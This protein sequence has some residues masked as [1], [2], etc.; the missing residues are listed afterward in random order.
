MSRRS[1]AV[2]LLAAV[3]LAITVLAP[4]FG[5]TLYSESF[6]ANPTASWTVN[7]G[8][9]DHAANFFFDYATVGIPAAP[10]APGTRGMKLQANQ[11]RGIFGGMSVS[12][13]GQSFAGPYTLAFDWWANF[14]GPFPAGGGGSTQLS[15]L[16]VQTSGTVSQWPGATQD[17]IWFGATGDGNSSSDWRVY[18]PSAPTAIP[19]RLRA[20]TRRAPRSAAAMRAIPT[21]QDSAQS[22]RRRRRVRS[23]HSRLA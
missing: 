10:S 11:S 22:A 21:M 23:M 4:A 15:T 3:P 17:S 14:N 20:S 9:S 7:P 8:P 16:G 19:T 18:S 12:P 6:E 5:A 2:L 13:T 1:R